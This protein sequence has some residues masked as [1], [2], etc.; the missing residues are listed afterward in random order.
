ME[1]WHVASDITI[2]LTVAVM[3]GIIA[4]RLGFSGVVGYLIAGTIV[5]PGMLD[6]VSADE[7][8]I[9]SIAE[10]GVA[11]LLFTIGLELQRARIIALFG[12][13]FLFGFLQILLTS[14]IL[15]K[16]SFQYG[17]SSINSFP[18]PKASLQ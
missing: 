12:R 10:I 14:C 18:G 11:L 4:E 15:L 9:H 2:L 8:A 13:G 3:F 6:W 16:N 5:G 17:S 1:F 7:Q